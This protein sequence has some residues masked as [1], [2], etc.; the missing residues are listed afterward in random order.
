[1]NGL[2]LSGVWVNGVWV[3][4]VWGNGVWVS[5]GLMIYSV[6]VNE[7]NDWVNTV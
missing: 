5:G 7:M 4:G 3:S 1:M 6:V 2:W